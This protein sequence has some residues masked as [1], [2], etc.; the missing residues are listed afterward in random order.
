[1]LYKQ[2]VQLLLFFS[3]TDSIEGLLVPTNSLNENESPS[4][5]YRNDFLV[6]VLLTTE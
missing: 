2:F 6:E 5:L 3:S 1:M 4:L